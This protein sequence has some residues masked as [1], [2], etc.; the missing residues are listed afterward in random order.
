MIQRSEP[1]MKIRG[2]A[3]SIVV[4]ALWLLIFSQAAK[5]LDPYKVL[6]VDRNASQR[7]VQK[8]F[9]KLSLQYHPD[10][11][12]NKGAQEKF[13]QI[14]NAYE[15]LSD[16]EKR[17]N[18]DMYGDERGSPGFNGGSPGFDAGNPGDNGGYTY[19]TSGGPGGWQHMGGQGNSK[20]FSFSFGN[21]GGQGSS[22][23]DLNDI[24]S[25]FFGGDKSGASHFG[26]FSGSSRTQSGG[27]GGSS[28]TQSG[29]FGGSSRSQSSGF[30]GTSWTQSGSGNYPKSIPD[31]NSQVFKKEIADQGITWLLLSYSPT[32][33]G[34]QY[35]ESIIEE[36]AT[37]LQGALKA[38]S[39]NCEN[40]PT[41]CKELGIY[42][43][44]APRVFVYSYKAIQSG[45]LVEYKGD[46]A[47]KNL[48][49]FC[50]EHLPIFSKRVDLDTFDFSSGTVE[51]LPRV[52]LLS[53]KK[54]TPVIWRALS[55]LYRKRFIFYDV[56]VHDASDKV[57]KKLGV[58]A[59]PAIVGWMTNGEKH[60]LRT[61]ISVKDLNSAIQELSTLLNGFAKKNKKATSSQT[62]K[63][64]TESMDK[65]IHLLTASNFDAICGET[66][67]VCLIGVFRSSKA[68][69]KV[70]SILSVVS[71]KSLSRRQ[72]P[73]SGSKDSISYT[74]LDATKQPAFLT[75]FD[76]SGFK[77][78]DKL[79]IAYKP[80]K[81][82]FAAYTREITVEEVE[83][84][85]SSVL[86][87]DIQ[88]TKIK[89]KPKLR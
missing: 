83:R 81:G 71:Q 73:Y 36:V 8:A 50:Q 53:T 22:N 78:F 14:N 31:I 59:L 57:V 28:R 47:T 20:S 11:N 37:S 30:S 10:K 13:A 76:N 82:K 23:F 3:L 43:R 72:N 49:G 64:E 51:R 63:P 56:E 58:D 79:L 19:F 67:P 74:L 69:E 1:R 85:I 34:I 6:G 40:E 27:F 66:I 12:K 24:F 45:S 7:E 62:K 29:G 9:H 52:M 77:S 75:A 89:Q 87:G 84:F 80:R 61:G 88:F 21:S 86:N 33:S 54:D 2:V 4:F 26:G 48:K 70:E 15:I 44:K 68:R 42:P 41:F 39:I 5:T 35:Y 38:G 16:E 17:K 18:Y 25:N 65:Q 32:L 55:G 60:V 46:W